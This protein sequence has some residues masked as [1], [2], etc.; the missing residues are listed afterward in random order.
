MKASWFGVTVAWGVLALAPVQAAGQGPGAELIHGRVVT[1]AGNVFEGFIRWDRNEAGWTDLLNGDKPFPP[2]NLRQ[3]ERIGLTTPEDRERSVELFGFRVSW[4]EDDRLE[5]VES[6]IRFGHLEALRVLDDQAVLLSLRN[7]EE[8]ELRNGSTDI[9]TDIRGILVQDPVRGD[10]EL[11]WHDL[12]RIE[13][14]PGTERAADAPAR[15][16]GTLVD[17]WGGT[18][19][20]YVVWDLDETF[21]NEVLDGDDEDGRGRQIPF[22]EIAAIERHGSR[23]ARV[24]LGNGEELVLTGSN[25]V[26]H[27]NR[28]IQISDPG[29]GQVRVGWNEFESLRLHPPTEPA[30]YGT[31]DG[32]HRL[33]GKVRTEDG[34]ELVGLI[35]WDNDEAWSWEMLDG[36]YRNVIYDVELGMVRSVE[37]R[38]GDGVVVTLR[39][40]RILELR[41]SNDVDEG[42]KGIVVELDDGALEGVR[43]EDV[44]QV[45]LTRPR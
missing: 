21:D 1:A 2:E 24:V 31:F 18:Y 40:G 15:L 10:V 42:N 13:F 41:H 25:D 20:G 8:V 32:G 43:W 27:S 26:D 17:R 38:P 7:G 33:Q 14:Y 22:R 11:G 37:K 19:T 30:G 6:G 36:S 5:E 29:L 39:D 9:G 4:E 3:A 23:G 44:R 12:D 45:E 34:R 28:G 35:R 16:H